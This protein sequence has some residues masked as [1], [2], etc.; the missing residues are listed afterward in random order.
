M[1]MQIG[2]AA[3]ALKM[4]RQWLWHLISEGAISTSEIAGKKFVVMDDRF[5][6]IKLERTGRKPRK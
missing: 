2:K 1:Y 4:S 5:K 3:D 6:A